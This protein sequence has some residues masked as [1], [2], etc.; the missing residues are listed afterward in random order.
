MARKQD[1]R[2]VVSRDFLDQL[3]TQSAHDTAV[4]NGK[5]ADSTQ[6]DSLLTAVNSDLTVP[7]RMVASDP[8]DL[9][10]TLDAAT[11][12][13]PGTG[14]NRSMYPIDDV[15][16]TFAGGTVTFPATSAGNI[17]PSVG[18]AIP[19]TTSNGQFNKL[20]IYIDSSSNIVLVEGTEGASV[21]AAVIPPEQPGMTYVGYVAF[22][23]DGGGNITDSASVS[24]QL[25][26]GDIY[27]FVAPSTGLAGMVN[28]D[29]VMKLLGGGNW[30]VTTSPVSGVVED[31][32]TLG[33][34]N[35][36]SGLS[37]P[38]RSFATSIT[39]SATASLTEVNGFFRMDGSGANDA[40]VRAY[41]YSDVAGQPGVVLDTSINAIDDTGLN[42]GFG[43][44]FLERTFTFSGAYAMNA[45]TTYW[46]V[47]RA[48]P[49]VDYSP[50]IQV[51]ENTNTIDGEASFTRAADID[52][53]SP[54]TN[55]L[56]ITVEASGIAT[57]T[58]E[59]DA[60]AY[61][62]VPG[63]ANDRNRIN[64]SASGVIISEDQVAYVDIN[65]IDPGVAT[66]LS[67]TVVDVDA[68]VNKNDRV[69]IA[70][71]NDGTIIVGDDS[72]RLI[73]GESQTLEA[74]AS[75]ETLALLGSNVTEA[76]SQP[77]Y[78]FRGAPERT[79]DDS[80]AMLDAMASMDTEL[81]K[82]FGQ[83][84]LEPH[85]TD[86]HRATV[87]GADFTM[88]DGTVLSQE[89]ASL[90]MEFTGAII[91][92]D[93][94]EILKDDDVTPL[95]IDFTPTVIPVNE[96]HW[97]S[98]SLVAGTQDAT[99]EA[100][101]VQFI[102]L[103]ASGT[104]AVA[105]DAPYA[106][107]GGSKKIGQVQ[108]QNL[109]GTATVGSIRQLGT[110]SGGGGND[111]DR[112]LKLIEGGTWALNTGST[113]YGTLIGPEV[114]AGGAGA[115]VSAIA[116]IGTDVYIGGGFTTVDGGTPANR[117]AKY[118]TVGGTW[119]ALGA[120]VDGSVN[121]LTVIGTDLYVG[122]FFN[123][124]DGSPASKV[125]K[126][127][128]VGGTWSA[129]GG[130]ISATVFGI[131]AVGTDLYI[132]GQFTTVDGGMAASRVARYDTVG[133]TWHAMGA[134][135]NN[136]SRTFELIGTDL[137]VGGNFTT[138]DGG[139][140]SEYIAKWDTVGLTWSALPGA[141]ST[142]MSLASIGTDLYLGGFFTTVDAGGVVANNV[143]KYDT[144]GDIWSDIG[145]A[146]SFVNS[147]AAADNYLFIGG[148]FTTVDGGTSANRIARYDTVGDTWS[149]IG[150]ANSSV[151][152]I[153]ASN[154]YV[155]VGGSFTNIGNPS[156]G[157]DYVGRFE[158]DAAAAALSWNADAYIQVPGQSNN[159]NTIS[160]SSVAVPDGSV[161]YVEINRLAGAADTLTPVV[162]T[163]EN[164]SP[165]DPNILIFARGVSDGIIVGTSSFKLTSGE[166][167]T[168]DGS[169][170]DQ[171]L[172]F[173]G[174]TGASDNSPDY[175]SNNTLVDGSSLVT[176]MGALDAQL[177]ILGGTL[178]SQNLDRNLKL[179]EGGTWSAT[180]A[181]A[182]FDNMV[183]HVADYTDTEVI[184]HVDDA[185]GQQFLATGTGIN[186]FT[187]EALE[188][189]A[190]TAT[191]TL[192]G[193]IWTSI[194]GY[195][196]AHSAL[197]ATS[198]NTINYAALDTTFG[199][200]PGAPITPTVFNFSGEVLTPGQVY[201]CIITPDTH[202]GGQLN[203]QRA[204][205][206]GI[207]GA[208]Q[209]VITNNWP[210]GSSV[211]SGRSYALA[212][213]QASAG[214]E[215]SWDADAYI[216]VPGVA[217]N[218]NTI[219]ASSIAI[220]DGSAAYVEINRDAGALD[221]L[222]P[223]IDTI[224]NIDQANTNILIFARGVSDGIIVGNNS[225]LL[226][227]G[228]SLELEG[229]LAEINR[230]NDQFRIRTTF[231]TNEVSV[232]SAETTM[233]DGTI[234][235]QELNG[236]VVDFTGTTINFTTGTAGINA[237][238][239]NPI[240]TA[241]GTDTHYQWFGIGL[242]PDSVG[243]DGRMTPQFVITAGANSD[244]VQANAPYPVI[245]GDKKI[246]AVLLQRSGSDAVVV[247]IS[248][249]SVG[250]SGG[251]AGDANSIV[252]TLKNQLNSSFYDA[253]TANVFSVDEEDKL[254]TGAS[255]GEY[256]LV[257]KNF[258]MDAAE[259]MVSSQM[260]DAQFLASPS[261]IS[262]VD[263]SMFWDLDTIDTAATYE[264]S[265]DGVEYQVVTMTR[266]NDTEVYTGNHAFDEEAATQELAADAAT[267][268]TFEM[269]NVDEYVSQAFTLANT[270]VI[271]DVDMTVTVNGSPVGELYVALYTDNA[272]DP[273]TLITESVATDIST[274]ST[275]ALTLDIP[276]TALAAGTYHMVLRTS[277]AYKS[278]F[279][280]STTSIAFNTNTAA[281]TPLQS[282]PDG[283]TWTPE[284]EGFTYDLQGSIM[285]LRVRVTAST[286]SQ[287]A[288]YGILY[289]PTTSGVVQGVKNRQVFSFNATDN[290]NE[291]ALTTFTP[292][293]DLLNVYLVET[294]QVFRNGAFQLD[295]RTIKFPVN[296][297]DNGGSPT[298]YTLIADQTIGN[299]FDNSDLNGLLLS[300]N[301][302]GSTDALVD[303]SVAG[304][305]I[306]LRRPDGTLRELT[307]D[308]SD[309][310]VIYSV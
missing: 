88:K 285:D 57:P 198:T 156:V 284:G 155:Y 22:G 62:Q 40:S 305:G 291:F 306:F 294:G 176:G 185:I 210:A 212:V 106:P 144:V 183:D 301:H 162:D 258:E 154:E 248:R 153:I 299:S 223:V 136:I 100:M 204:S 286:T 15:V 18:T 227:E 131:K 109:A 262:E 152:S 80:Q 260:L 303:K 249:F 93:T 213:D 235:R 165:Y 146:S 65:R 2:Q 61:M 201:W 168:L 228:E 206:A 70:R 187:M 92:F 304:R 23:V 91:N 289:D 190:G 219:S 84:R 288:G 90:V 186:S 207:D 3:T 274:M 54:N 29:R 271:K 158:F 12:T 261:I 9:I 74:S 197:V 287:L 308:D 147:V 143:A 121:S 214:A 298:P 51:L 220:P 8:A 5:K 172:A 205:G 67:I 17:T 191:G 283:T 217:N 161:A 310:I 42:T 120:G 36:N 96:Y 170:S 98:V 127:D 251:G 75:N 157:A 208:S 307:I 105:A 97:Y 24:G 293:A 50:H 309:S 52:P 216:Q 27:Q 13:N 160:A 245:S 37:A 182:T 11:L 73:V 135:T 19:I 177:G 59:W 10:I 178:D 141:N 280:A 142:I 85:P 267:D 41:L 200:A 94:G 253:V 242:L 195:N 209:S 133:D 241:I 243:V 259:T 124:A 237:T 255:T 129:L 149:D 151:N 254:D 71:E 33:D 68:Y 239:L 123:N 148:G 230:Y 21:A 102:V 225:F 122:G 270:S 234:L 173:I 281:A 180:A 238:G 174:A 297:F 266:N 78:A 101:E 269:D 247:E 166:S 125:A 66:D 279:V 193:E 110:G 31:Y 25:I 44:P 117:V 58:L 257:T 14:R 63:M 99:T 199:G 196:T 119:S 203:A 87:T 55:N 163:I 233:L 222:T 49:G 112:N 277:D 137:Y 46:I 296:T 118:D 229:A 115:S 126:Y 221:T 236:F 76:T 107:F 6:V 224:E 134:G 95:G 16:S 60:H 128:T 292:D 1:A 218:R 7:I 278:T 103:P 179:I 108:I 145:G 38:E 265:R 116:V 272:G 138:I 32:V 300:G 28:Q 164:V 250:A 47:L 184:N 276:D 167:M 30:S 72:F 114:L 268:G 252:E 232:E 181:T 189:F 77:T 215:L 104:D 43:D 53:W 211:S 231:N 20:G 290:L 169:S 83:L 113:D 79:I 69:I 89:I 140:P 45:G 295:G 273:D 64:V 39:P 302:L 111:Q 132:G 139:T 159:R 26:N 263:L 171:N 4:L 86:A 275:G 256:S 282:S 82:W 48:E 202:T 188:N 130:A 240:T 34:Q 81:D 246:G 35:G 194:G 150:G 226:K 192:R 56:A 175:P 264:V 244:A